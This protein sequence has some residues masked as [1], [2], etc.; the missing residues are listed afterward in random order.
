MKVKLTAVLCFVLLILGITKVD[1]ETNIL[2][3]KPENSFI[4]SVRS[5][6]Y[7]FFKKIQ[8]N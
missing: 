4:T 6:I 8:K 3:D 1:K 2:L 5:D 7:D